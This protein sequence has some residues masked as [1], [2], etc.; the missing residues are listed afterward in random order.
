MAV[1]SEA[2]GLQQGHEQVGRKPGDGEREQNQV[3]AHGSGPLAG[4][5]VE[6]EE[7]EARGDEGEQQEVEHV[8]LHSGFKPG[9][10][11]CRLSGRWDRRVL[12]I[13]AA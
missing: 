11:A 1:L 5:E 8:G 4:G 13:K 9:C 2:L 7:G 12:A 6:R 3:E 10:P